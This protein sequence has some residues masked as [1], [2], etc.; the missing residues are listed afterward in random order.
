MPNVTLS[1]EQVEVIKEALDR[2][3][4]L[5]SIVIAGKPNQQRAA[6]DVA[7]VLGTL[8]RGRFLTPNR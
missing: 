7:R 6:L 4:E 8:K 1:E 3:D 5:V 2:A